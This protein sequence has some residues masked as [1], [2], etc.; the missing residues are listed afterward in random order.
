MYSVLHST[1]ISLECP[2]PS[3]VLFCTFI[4]DDRILLLF[5]NSQ[6]TLI[7]VSSMRNLKT[8]HSNHL[9]IS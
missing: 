2:I 1:K 5:E 7:D 4:T 8:V 3:A 9:E 6:Y